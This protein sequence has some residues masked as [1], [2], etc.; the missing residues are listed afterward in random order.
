[1]FISPGFREW[2]YPKS[3]DALIAV[4]PGL[5]IHGGP[6]DNESVFNIRAEDNKQ[7][8]RLFALCMY[9]LLL[10]SH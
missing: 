7:G 6:L 3:R 8:F 10:A 1:M 5:S 4:T 2:G 9:S